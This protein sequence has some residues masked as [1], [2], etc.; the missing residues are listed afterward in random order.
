MAS[1]TM[2]LGLGGLSL[3]IGFIL[4]IYVLASQLDL[5]DCGM[6]SGT[7]DKNYVVIEIVYVFL[8]IL[9]TVLVMM[10]MGAKSKETAD[11]KKGGKKPENEST[12]TKTNN[13]NE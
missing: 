7:T 9:G 11:E 8:L 1:S 12:K 5:C 2:Y 10:G 3:F 4:L 13:D 6:E